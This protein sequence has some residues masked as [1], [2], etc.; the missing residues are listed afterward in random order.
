MKWHSRIDFGSIASIRVR[1]GVGLALS[2]W[3]ASACVTASKNDSPIV[4]PAS[5][6]MPARLILGA[7]DLIEVRVY[8]EPDLHG[9][10][11][12]NP[13]GEIDFP[14]IGGVTVFGKD[15]EKLG[16]EIRERLAHG[17]LN[18]PQVT[19]FVHEYKSHMVHVIGQV[20]RGG[21]FP[22]IAGMSVLHAV[23]QAGGFTRLAAKNRVRV[24]RKIGGAEKVFDLPVNDIGAGLS[25]N[26]EL[27][28]GDIVFIPESIF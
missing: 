14:L 1:K 15:A 13:N 26:F 9:T 19:V 5:D 12:I 3:L 6:T 25:P 16:H 20:K 8:R 4:P 2:T 24:T 11:R 28:S 7:G 18:N 22:F 17:Y 23:S 10:Y 21:S 27:Q